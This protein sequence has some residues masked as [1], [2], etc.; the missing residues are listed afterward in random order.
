MTF[1]ITPTGF[2]IKTQADILASL[3]SAARG[4]EGLDSQIEYGIEDPL[5]QIFGIMSSALAEPWEQLQEVYGAGDIDAAEDVALANLG[6]LLGTT[7]GGASQ[8]YVLVNMAATNGTI[9]PAGTFIA[10][11]GNEDKRFYARDTLTADVT[12][13]ILDAVFLAEVFGPVAAAA[14]S[15]TVI[16]N[17]IAGWS[18]V[19]NPLDAQLGQDVETQGEFR[20]DIKDAAQ[21]QGGSTVSAIR[22]DV[23]ALNETLEGTPI[24]SV[25]VSE[26]TKAF[27]DP[28]GLPGNSFEVMIFDSPAVNNNLI[29]QAIWD[30]KPA[31]VY[32]H[33]NQ[34]GIATDS[35]G[36]QHSIKFSRPVAVPIYVGIS[37]LVDLSYVGNVAAKESI[38]AAA[39]LA[40]PTGADV[41]WKKVEALALSVQGIR[42]ILVTTL[43]RV[44]APP[45]AV[46]I[47]I[48]NRE[49]ASWDASQF[50]FIMAPYVDY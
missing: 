36:R 30:S 39:K 3:Q 12:D 18:S 38:I 11:E 25:T 43:N 24:Q 13:M 21:V 2:V 32:A 16:V 7:R 49:I 47:P 1:G 9:I 37:F 44:G 50:T 40:F 33:G 45:L 20:Q 34:S 4:P 15:M 46:N 48:S 22:A 14:G 8:S 35:L 6:T 17:P 27:T 42:D 41:I 28:S 19:T 10:Q 31:T 26:N 23:L 29:A 5:G